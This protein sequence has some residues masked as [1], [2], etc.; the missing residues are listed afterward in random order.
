MTTPVT[1][2]T[3]SQSP[4]AP[5]TVV[6]RVY[7]PTLEA[8]VL[9]KADEEMYMRKLADSMFP[10]S[11]LLDY[12]PLWEIFRGKELVGEPVFRGFPYRPFTDPALEKRA[13]AAGPL[14]TDIIKQQLDEFHLKEQAR[15]R[16]RFEELRQGYYAG[17]SGTGSQDE[18]QGVKLK[19]SA[20]PACGNVSYEV[21]DEVPIQS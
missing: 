9:S 3:C 15:R 7:L 10:R 16:R 14:V 21:D 11:P 13:V 2:T 19:K 20:C 18:D 8:V 17:S 6:T 1:S 12:L 4:P 5:S